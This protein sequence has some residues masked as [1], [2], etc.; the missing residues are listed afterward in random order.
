[1]LKIDVEGMKKKSLPFL[2][3]ENKKLFPKTIIIEQNNDL[4]DGSLKPF[5]RVWI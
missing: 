2:K 1:M 4:W 5:K 3:D